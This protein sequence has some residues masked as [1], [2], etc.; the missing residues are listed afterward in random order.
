MLGSYGLSLAFNA[1]TA[2]T[3]A[4]LYGYT[5]N[6]YKTLLEYLDERT[7]VAFFQNPL[8]L[9]SHLLESYRKN[10]EAYRAK[11]DGCIYRTEMSL[12]YAVPGSLLHEAASSTPGR[13]DYDRFVQKLHSSHDDYMRQLHSCQTELGA[14]THVGNFGRELGVFLQKTSEELEKKERVAPAT[15]A[16]IVAANEYI[17]HN[18]EFQINLWW[19]MLSQMSILKDRIQTH[20]NLVRLTHVSYG[21]FN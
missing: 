18:I 7:S 3:Q 6:D 13:M 8:L 15:G 17:G 5:D 19:S 4:L 1:Q 9:A 2:S 10:A 16:D 12:G 21:G 20:I 11:V 14:L